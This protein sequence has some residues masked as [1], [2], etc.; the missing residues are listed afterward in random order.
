MPLW[1][2]M[3]TAMS[4]PWPVPAAVALRVA[5]EVTRSS[6]TKNKVMKDKVRWFGDMG[7]DVGVIGG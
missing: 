2:S 1:V 6:V 3:T 4:P 7:G 5:E